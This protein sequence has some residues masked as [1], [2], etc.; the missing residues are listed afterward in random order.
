MKVILLDHVLFIVYTVYTA[1]TVYA[2][3]RS[4]Q[5]APSPANRCRAAGQVFSARSTALPQRRESCKRHALV[6]LV[7]VLLYLLFLDF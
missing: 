6:T 4:L 3:F 2:Q 5:W 1:D 7:A